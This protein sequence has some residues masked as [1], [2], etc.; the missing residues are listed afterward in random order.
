MMGM[1]NRCCGGS[2]L[3]GTTPHCNWQK[4][5]FFVMLP[6]VAGYALVVARKPDFYTF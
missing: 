1:N 5:E 3:T 4:A 6:A 2:F